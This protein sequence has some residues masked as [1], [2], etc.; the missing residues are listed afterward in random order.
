MGATLDPPLWVPARFANMITVSM[1]WSSTSTPYSAQKCCT[2]A[3]KMFLQNWLSNQHPYNF[4][5]L[6]ESFDN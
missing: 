3:L 1:L 5:R 6:K 4:R 2:L